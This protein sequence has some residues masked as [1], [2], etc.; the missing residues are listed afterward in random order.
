MSK[1]I[2]VCKIEGEKIQNLEGFYEQVSEQM[3]PKGVQF[4]KNMDSFNEVLNSSG[5]VDI[6]WQNADESQKNL[7]E[8]H[9]QK[10]LEMIRDHGPEGGKPKD[11]V[12]LHLA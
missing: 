7:G 12:H 11:N 2:P 8:E 6:V 3:V 4:E 9:F 5:G 10:I 1:K